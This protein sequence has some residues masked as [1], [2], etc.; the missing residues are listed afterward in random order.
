MVG[1]LTSSRMAGSVGW[2]AGR[3]HAGFIAPG[4]DRLERVVT[5]SRFAALFC[6][7]PGDPGAK[8]S[9]AAKQQCHEYPKDTAAK[10]GAGIVAYGRPFVP[11]DRA[12]AG[13]SLMKSSKATGLGEIGRRAW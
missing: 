3:R 12:W 10:A 8:R 7:R 1:R 4:H 6:L 2:N 13:A 9:I 11:V 5:P